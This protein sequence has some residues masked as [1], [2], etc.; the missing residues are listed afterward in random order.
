MDNKGKLSII[1]TK[2]GIILS[3]KKK[4]NKMEKWKLW[5]EIESVYVFIFG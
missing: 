4:H 5:F 3:K 2:S 1:V